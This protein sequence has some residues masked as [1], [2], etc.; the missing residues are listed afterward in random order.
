M[1]RIS[2]FVV[3]SLA[4]GAVYACNN[5]DEVVPTTAIPT[6]GVRFIHAVPDTNPMD[7]RFVDIVE[8]NAQFGIAFRNN[9]VTTGGVTASTQITYKPAM[10][11]SRHFRIFI[12]DTGAA[13]A[14]VIKDTTVTLT[15]GSNYTAL[16]WGNARPLAPAT[17]GTMKLDFYEETVPD[18]A[19]NVSIRIMNATGVAINGEQYTNG[20]ASTGTYTTGWTAIAPLT[21]SA[22]FS[23]LPGRVNVRV[24]TTLALKLIAADPL[25]LLGVKAMFSGDTLCS[26]TGPTTALPACDQQAI[27]GS[28]IAGSA[29]SGIIYPRSVAGSKA[30]SAFTTPAASWMWDRRPPRGCVAPYC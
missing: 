22:Y 15:A 21:R 5:L 11:G 7:L 29:I 2:R 27:G 20:G 18:P 23:R 16:L 28:L 8:N 26:G 1:Q 14:T 17:V 9:P 12:S 4:A 13:A 24:D 19:G 25:A 3:L 6:A 30:P 10:A